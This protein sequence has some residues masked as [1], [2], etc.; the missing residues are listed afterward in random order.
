[1]NVTNFCTFSQPNLIF[2]FGRENQEH[3][4]CWFNLY[5]MVVGTGSYVKP[6]IAYITMKKVVAVANILWTP[7][8]LQHC[9]FILSLKCTSG[10]I[11]VP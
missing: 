8:V 2:S 5:L 1:M 9:W 10:Y 3:T 6:K 7:P 4:D 11:F